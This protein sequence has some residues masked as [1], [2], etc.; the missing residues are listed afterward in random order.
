M[1][2]LVVLLLVAGCAAN[3]SRAVVGV[4]PVAA[5][6]GFLQLCAGPDAGPECP[7]R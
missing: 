1:K 5:P 2:L 4:D 3:P 6:E 7:K